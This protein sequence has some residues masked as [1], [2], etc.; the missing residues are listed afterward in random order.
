MFASP[1][2][3]CR[4]LYGRFPDV[5]IAVPPYLLCA[6]CR[7]SR[8]SPFGQ[9]I[10]EINAAAWLIG[11]GRYDSSSMS[12]F[13]PDSCQSSSVTFDRSSSTDSEEVMKPMSIAFSLLESL[14]PTRLSLVVM[15]STFQ[16]AALGRYRARVLFVGA[17]NSRSLESSL[18][19]GFRRKN[20]EA[21][22]ALSRMS[23]YLPLCS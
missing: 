9:Q 8:Y 14:P 5:Q 12:L 18:P 21:S 2:F 19:S 7:L 1:N 23:R 6:L 13:A 4:S 3:P 11:C 16:V 17:E 22:S 15:M 10:P 20:T